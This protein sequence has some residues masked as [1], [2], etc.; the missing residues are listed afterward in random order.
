M[1]LTGLRNAESHGRV[2]YGQEQR[3]VFI[4]GKEVTLSQAQSYLHDIYENNSNFLQRNKDKEREIRV[5]VRNYIWSN[6]KF[7]KGEGINRSALMGGKRRKLMPEFGNSHERPDLTQK[8]GGYQCMVLDKCGLEKSSLEDRALFWKS[9]EDVVKS[10]IQV[11]RSTAVKITKVTLME[12]KFAHP[13][14][15][16]ILSEY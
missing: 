11:K 5:V 13:S 9:Y 8:N 14:L 16:V 10:E 6:T 15:L 12:S 3:K 7:V 4:K 2:P 1:D